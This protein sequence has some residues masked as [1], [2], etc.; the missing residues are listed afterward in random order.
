MT[1]LTYLEKQMTS[2]TMTK[3]APPVWLLAFW[4]EIHD[5]TL[6]KGFDCFAEDVTCDLDQNNFSV[7]RYALRKSSQDGIQIPSYR[8]YP[9]FAQ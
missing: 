2:R 4:K 7:A 6:G 8:E 5:K 3:T 9:R 1:T